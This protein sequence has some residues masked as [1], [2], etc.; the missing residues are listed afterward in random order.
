MAGAVIAALLADHPLAREGGRQ[1]LPDQDFDRAVRLA[2]QVLGALGLDLQPVPS[3][4]PGPGQD[5]GFAR[6]PFGDG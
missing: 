6:D 5:S 2:D 4:E 3:V 1:A